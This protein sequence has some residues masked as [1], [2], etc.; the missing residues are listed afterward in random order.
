MIFEGRNKAYGAYE[1]RTHD[2][3]RNLL[4]L[5]LSIL[6]FTGLAI[7]PLFKD[8]SIKPATIADGQI[9][10]TTVDIDQPIEKPIVLPVY[11]PPQAPRPS[12]KFDV[13]V[14]VND[15]V[16]SK[17]MATQAEVQR[18]G[19][20]IGTI[21]VDG[22]PEEGSEWKD[23]RGK[24]TGTQAAIP[25]VVDQ[26]PEYKGD[27]LGF[28]SSHLVYPQAAREMEIS[29]RVYIQFVVD[30]TG[31]V[32]N[33]KLFRGIGAGCDEE[34]LRVVRMMGDWIP[35][36]LDGKPVASYFTLPVNFVLDNR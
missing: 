29:G 32:S 35:A 5:F 22:I 8:Y 4:G 25:L 33:I 12:I 27:L 36:K 10:L 20:L 15:D 28:L 14:I 1:H 19:Y 34:A 23:D 24:L 3:R 9:S 18:P 16:E 21:N 7:I 31:K 13:P 2:D 30:A 11:E 17:G 6:F 26:V